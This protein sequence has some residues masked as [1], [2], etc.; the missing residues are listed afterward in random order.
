MFTPQKEGGTSWQPICSVQD[1]NQTYLYD[2]KLARIAVMSSRTETNTESLLK[3][4]TGNEYQKYWIRY[5]WQRSW[6]V[7]NRVIRV[8]ITFSRGD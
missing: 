1:V 2:Q 8:N 5:Q 4:K 7:H 6:K 3:I